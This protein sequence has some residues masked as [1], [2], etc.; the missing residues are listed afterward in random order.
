MAIARNPEPML[1]AIEG[2]EASRASD[3]SDFGQLSEV[4]PVVRDVVRDRAARRPRIAVASS[5]ADDPRFASDTGQGLDG[6]VGYG[7]DGNIGCTG[8]LL[9]SGQHII[10]AAHCVSAQRNPDRYTVFF[11]LPEGRVSAK[12]RQVIVNPNWN[13]NDP[14]SNNDVA[15]L[16]LERT[17]PDTAD[18]YDIYRGSDEVGQIATLVGYGQPGIGSQGE[19]TGTFPAT[20]RSGTNR[21]DALGDVFNR[22]S[23]VDVKP[24][25]QL[26][27]DFDSGRSANDG[28]GRDFRINDLGTDREVGSSSGDSGGPLL[29]NGQVAGVVSYAFVPEAN[30]AD[31]TGRNDTSYGEIFAA[32]RLSAFASWIDGAIAQTF[33][34]NDVLIGTNR[35]DTLS[36]NQ[37]IDTLSGRGG[38]DFLS[39]G[40]DGDR[41]EGG[42]DSDRLFGNLGS[43]TLFGEAGDDSLFGGQGDD[44]L[45]GG[46]GNDWLSGDR[47]VDVLTGGP[48][49]D[50]FILN[51]A[52][53]DNNPA[54]VDILTDFSGEDVIG[55]SGG[56]TAGAIALEVGNLRNTPG[57][58]IR[59]GGVVLGFVN[60]IDPIQLSGRFEAI[61]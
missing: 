21:I 42:D 55:L 6:V 4:N 36:G 20:R 18:R 25:T 9:L 54:L 61:G 52:T 43:D 31:P 39:G 38:S 27:Y 2:S 14:D 48:G 19:L 16:W 50:R 1:D 59:G 17:A 12:V 46:E 28:L 57:T 15:I 23:G 33:S 58:L 44:S 13:S 24:G 37:G 53:S 8:T 5:N 41:L 49:V 34:G 32:T 35:P 60:N 7:R 11:D 51:P 3:F 26:A 10:T 47:G 45:L 56:L 22:D 40:R 29:L 30:G